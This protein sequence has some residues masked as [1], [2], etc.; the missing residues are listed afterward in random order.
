MMRK[1]MSGLRGAVAEL[2]VC[3][4]SCRLVEPGGSSPV[5]WSLRLGIVE[6]YEGGQ[7][8]SCEL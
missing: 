4:D 2:Q 7:E 8:V 1:L 5:A 3:W 6:L